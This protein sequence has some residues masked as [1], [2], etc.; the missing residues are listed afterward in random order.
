MRALR[1]SGEREGKSVLSWMAWRSM[2]GSV[3]AMWGFV[4]GLAVQMA[5]MVAGREALHL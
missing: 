3:N 2:I 1:C 5:T 4:V